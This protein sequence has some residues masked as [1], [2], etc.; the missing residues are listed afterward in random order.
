LRKLYMGSPFPP[1]IAEPVPRT[2]GRTCVARGPLV[3]N[4]SST[5]S[6]TL[7]QAAPFPFAHPLFTR[8][9][10]TDITYSCRCRLRESVFQ[11]VYLLKNKN[12]SGD[13]GKSND[14]HCKS[15]ERNMQR[16][17]LLV[18]LTIGPAAKC[19]STNLLKLA[20]KSIFHAKPST[21]KNGLSQLTVY[22]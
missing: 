22:F 11:A 1:A 9:G 7:G 13:L 15:R 2:A 17:Y 20:S 18:R 12:P 5:T 4:T 16:H 21:T 10:A 8:F 14:T 19:H 6:V 3:L